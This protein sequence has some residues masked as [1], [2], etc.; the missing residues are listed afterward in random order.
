MPDCSPASHAPSPPA[1]S[2]TAGVPAAARPPSPAALDGSLVAALRATARRVTPQRLVLHRALH[3]LGRH[4]TVEEVARAAAGRA[5]GISGPTA[6]AALDL[7]AELGLAR[8]VT[9]PGGPVL[10]DPRVDD[11]AHL[12]CRACGAVLDVDGA[13]DAAP[14]I[15]AA[16]A[17]GARV[18]RAQVV[19]DGLCPRCAAG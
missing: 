9:V 11:H 6:Y 18:D 8:R 4:A 13:V 15:A 19:L 5:P 10:Y 17:S 16:A 2:P 1:R 14:A 12:A 3:E 7:F